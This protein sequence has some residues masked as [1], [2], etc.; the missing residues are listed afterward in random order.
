MCTAPPNEWPEKWFLL[1]Q[2][3]TVDT[4]FVSRQRY[5]STC[6]YLV[7]LVLCLVRCTCQLVYICDTCF[8]CLQ[9]YV[10]TCLYLV[11]LVLCLFR[12]TCQLVYIWWH[13]FYVSSEV[14]VNL[15]ISGDTYFMC[16]QRYVS[17][18]LYLV[19]LVLCVFRGTCQLVYIWWRL[20][21]VSSE[22]H[23]NMP[24]GGSHRN[25]WSWK[26]NDE[27]IALQ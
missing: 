25:I 4:C 15:F 9:R 12:G 11:T 16:L 6:L 2:H 14:R 10:S 22:V 1:N 19:T 20:F 17:T 3:F 18:C 21:Y 7:T 23:V 24:F 13:L 27:G 5:V 8:M 26:Q